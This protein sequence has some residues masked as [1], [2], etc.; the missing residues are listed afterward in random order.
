MEN[1]WHRTP[2]HVHALEISKSTGQFPEFFSG[3]LESSKQSNKHRNLI[4]YKFG[5]HFFIL[6][7]ERVQTVVLMSRLGGRRFHTVTP[8]GK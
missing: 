2:F 5:T 4:A 3:E 8:D 6:D 7:P 1:C